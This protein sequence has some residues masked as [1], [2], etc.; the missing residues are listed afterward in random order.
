[1]GGVLGVLSLLCGGRGNH[2]RGVDGKMNEMFKVRT[3]NEEISWRSEVEW[4][5][6]LMPDEV[7]RQLKE[8]IE[9]AIEVGEYERC[10]ISCGGM[11]CLVQMIDDEMRVRSLEKQGMSYKEAMDLIV[12]E[13]RKEDDDL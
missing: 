6:R 2:F 10:P 9:Y 3:Y 8:I 12:S 1:M 13:R 7:L 5:Y 11:R 4:L